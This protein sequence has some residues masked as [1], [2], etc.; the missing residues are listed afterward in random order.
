MKRFTIGAMVLAAGLTAA[1]CGGSNNATPTGPS[2]TGPIVFSVQMSAANEVPPITNAES[3][4]RG[5]ATIT[6]NV[7]RDASG[8]PTGSGS[9]NFSVQLSGFPSNTAAIAAHIHP[10]A[11]GVNGTVLVPVTGLS[12]AAPILMTDGTGNLTFNNIDL[13]QTNAQAILNNPA[14]YYFNVHTPA[15]GGGAVRG[16]LVRTQ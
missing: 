10:G 4:G 6:F 13:S 7:P 5:T 12:A 14:G 9:A 15:N 8:N 1:R 16:Q 3:N 11:A 2:N